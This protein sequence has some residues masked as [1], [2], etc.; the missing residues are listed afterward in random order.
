MNMKRVII[1]LR[2]D[3]YHSL[4]HLK[5]LIF[6]IPFTVFWFISLRILGTSGN[7]F[8][9][10][11]GGIMLISK[12]TSPEIAQQL[13]VLNPP[14]L[15][16]FLLISI[17]VIP[18]FALL[19][20]NNQLASDAS[21]GSLRY[22]LSR[23]SRADIFLSR[24]LSAYLIIATGF[25]FACLASTF[26]SLHIDKH[27][28]DTTI[29]Y[30][31]ENLSLVLL[32]TLPYVAFMTIISALMSSALGTILMGVC[33]Y[34]MTFFVIIYFNDNTPAISYLLPSAYREK[35]TDIANNDLTVTIFGL[36]AMTTIYLCIAW[37][38][39]RN[40]NI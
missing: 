11:I 34:F 15:S 28:Y 37:V 5:G 26:I 39:F 38:I 9:S 31:L 7:E 30:A 32:Y 2:F 40:R 29:F 35:L 36:L 3:F 8:L 12:L 33:V 13:L 21:S 14:I 19:G 4:L 25:C 16:L 24:F 6:L 10:S 22:L 18:F 23:C 20:A 17:A 1:L 27:A